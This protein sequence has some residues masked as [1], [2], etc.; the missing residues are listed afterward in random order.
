MSSDSYMSMARTTQA[1]LDRVRVDDDPLP[2]LLRPDSPQEFKPARD[3]VLVR[4]ATPEC[5]TPAGILLPET[6]QD[7]RQG[8]GEVMAAG[9]ESSY[10]KGTTVFFQPYAGYGVDLPGGARGAEYLLMKN[11]EILAFIS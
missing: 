10:M 5:Q 3:M 8:W 1:T 11:E 9:P 2:H 6:S 7:K 4:R